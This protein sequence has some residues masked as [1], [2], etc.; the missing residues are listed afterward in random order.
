MVK[1][2]RFQG[3]EGRQARASLE[4]SGRKHERVG[5]RKSSPEGSEE[6]WFHS[7]SG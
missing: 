7:M 6:S 4:K 2:G 5:G 3:G 1:E